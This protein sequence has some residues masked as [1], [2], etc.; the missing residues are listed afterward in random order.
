MNLPKDLEKNRLYYIDP[1]P[2]F[3]DFTTS[4]IVKHNLDSFIDMNIDKDT[5]YIKLLRPTTSPL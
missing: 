2:A 3:R 1:S 4:Y 5:G